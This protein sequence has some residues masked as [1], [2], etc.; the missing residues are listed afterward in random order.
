MILKK[1]D[2]NLQRALSEACLTP[3]R[4]LLS[5]TFST[6]KSGAGSVVVSGD[7]TG[8]TT[9]QAINIIQRLQHPEGEST[10]ALFLAEKKENVLAVLEIFER[11]NIYNALRVYGTN[12]KMDI[13][14][15]KN[16]ISLGND[17]LVC[18][19]E[20]ANALFSGAGFNLN[21]VKIFAVDDAARIF[22]NR[23]DAIVLR[24][25]ES[26]RRPQFVLTALR[27]TEKLATMAGKLID[28]PY[29][30]DFTED[31]Q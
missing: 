30:F 16:L 17:V 23:H 2:P 24:L 21:T 5:Q 3:P 14:Q 31:D 1:I 15:D 18:T 29:W 12:D 11:L 6:L 19:P 20:K 28:E 27:E 10:R 4:P 26:A 22:A 9:L 25:A 7:G 13:D 8:K